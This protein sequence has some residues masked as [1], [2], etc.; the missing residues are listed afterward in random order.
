MEQEELS[1]IYI[2]SDECYVLEFEIKDIDFSHHPLFGREHVLAKKLT[3]LHEKYEYR[4]N[5]GVTRRL[6]SKL[7]ALRTAHDNLKRIMETNDNEEMKI[8]QRE[9]LSRYGI[10]S[11]PFFFSKREISEECI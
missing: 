7:K 10:F 9:R 6:A 2:H 11:F 5:T 1:S 3:Q 8:T 4:V